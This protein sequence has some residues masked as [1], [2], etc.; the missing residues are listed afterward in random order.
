MI[1]LFFVPFLQDMLVISYVCD[2]VIVK[3][4]SINMIL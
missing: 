1:L 3:Y 2:I 4:L